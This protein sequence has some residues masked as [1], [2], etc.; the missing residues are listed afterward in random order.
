MSSGT[1]D[2]LFLQRMLPDDDLAILGAGS[3]R[4]SCCEPLALDRL[5]RRAGIG[6]RLEGGGGSCTRWSPAPFHGA[7]F[8]QVS[9]TNPKSTPDMD[10]LRGFG[11]IARF[12]QALDEVV[13]LSQ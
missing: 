1:D 8:R 4:F 11:T 3:S 10:W 9:D 6:R 5:S 12:R 7:L 13:H 2:F